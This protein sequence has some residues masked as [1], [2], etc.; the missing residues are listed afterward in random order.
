MYALNE[1]VPTKLSSID[2]VNASILFNL[3][4]VDEVYALRESLP[5][6]AVNEL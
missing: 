3:L 1:P 5:F 2:A 6:D 4:S